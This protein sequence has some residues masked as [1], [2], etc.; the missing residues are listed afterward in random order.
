MDCTNVPTLS[1]EKVRPQQIT[2]ATAKTF[3]RDDSSNQFM[4]GLW[5]IRNTLGFVSFKLNIIFAV[6]RLNV[7]GFNHACI[8]VVID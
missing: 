8:D 6:E 7:T 4:I 5:N 2:L 1:G 3:K